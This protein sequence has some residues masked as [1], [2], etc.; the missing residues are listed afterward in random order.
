MLSMNRAPSDKRKFN[1]LNSMMDNFFLLDGLL[2]RYQKDKE[3]RHK[4]QLCLPTS[5]VDMILHW[6]HS[7]I[8]GAHMGMTKGMETISQRYYIPDLARHLRAYIL[9]CHKCQQFKQGQKIKRPMQTRINLDTPSLS[10][11]S[12]DIKYMPTAS[13]GHKYILVCIDEVTNYLVVSPMYTTQTPEICHTLIN[14]IFAY[15]GPP[16]HIICDKDPAFMSKIAQYLYQEADIKCITASPT[17]HQSLKAEHGIKSVTEIL[18]KHLTGLGKN[19]P[20]FLP[21]AM[22]SYNSFSTP[23]L[24]KLSPMELAIGRKAKLMP[25]MEI[26][27]D[28]KVSVTHREYLDT[29]KKQLRYLRQQVERYR[30]RRIGMMNKDRTP[31]AFMEGQI[32]YLYQP[33]GAMLQTGTRKIACHYV[34]PLAIYKALDDNQYLIMSLDGRLFPNVIEATRLKPGFVQTQ[35]GSVATLAELQAK[36]RGC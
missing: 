2:F 15:F 21:L 12:M 11:F 9:G 36:M 1:R 19:W 22:L 30:N 10:R 31:H 5:M 18:M 14:K 25:E 26:G 29:L 6:Y 34:G 32:V 17:N 28:I 27:P 3:D 16:T 35:R 13:T 20:N 24:D 7:S 8:I 4:T 33:K 23:N